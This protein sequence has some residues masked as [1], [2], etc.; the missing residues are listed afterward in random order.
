MNIFFT[1]V[2]F[3]LAFSSQKTLAQA[4]R[5]PIQ[6]RAGVIVSVSLDEIPSSLKIGNDVVMVCESDYKVSFST[7]AFS[8][9]NDVCAVIINHAKSRSYAGI[10]ICRKIQGTWVKDKSLV[11][12]QLPKNYREISELGAI[13]HDATLLLG[14]FS[15]IAPYEDG[16]RVFFEWE[17][18]ETNG[19][20]KS[21]GLNVP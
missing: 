21:K 11:L 20:F 15:V 7:V 5:H 1:I 18:W 16:E 4:K 19:T 10:Q 9:N 3:T 12:N 2:F 8:K 13:N 17:T 6:L 14:K